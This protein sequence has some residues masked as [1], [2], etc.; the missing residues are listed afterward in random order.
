MRPR[1]FSSFDHDGYDIASLSRAGLPSNF[2]RCI[3][4]GVGVGS[5]LVRLLRYSASGFL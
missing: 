3:L 1:D 2:L 5:S 4:G